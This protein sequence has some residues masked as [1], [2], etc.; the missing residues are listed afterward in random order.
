MQNPVTESGISVSDIYSN[1]HSILH[2]VDK[3]NPT[4]GRPANPA[5]DSQYAN[6]EYGV[7]KWNK[8]TFGALI[9]AQQTLSESASSS[10]PEEEE[11]PQQS[12]RRNRSNQ[13]EDDD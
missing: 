10:E 1:V 9:E 4:G 2:F 5:S 11:T 8:E 13:N 12:D 7:Q 3:N 6:W